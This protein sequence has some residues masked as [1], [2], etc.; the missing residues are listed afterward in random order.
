M[1]ISVWCCFKIGEILSGVRGGLFAALFFL[2]FGIANQFLLVRPESIMLPLVLAGIWLGLKFLADPVRR[3]QIIW[4]ALLVGLSL[5]IFSS[6]SCGAV[7][8]M[9]CLFSQPAITYDI[10]RTFIKKG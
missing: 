9:A 2:P 8:D 6:L 5:Y 4:G 10:F 3:N 7:M 1:L